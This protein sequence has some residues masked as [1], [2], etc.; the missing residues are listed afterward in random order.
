MRNILR[1][2][3]YRLVRGKSLYIT[4]AVLLGV[5]LLQILSGANMN[6]GVSTGSFVEMDNMENMMEA[7]INLDDLFHS[8]TGAEAPFQAM[9]VTSN[10]LY[11]ML[12]LFVIIGTAD[13]SSGGAKN[14]LSGGVSRAKYYASKLILSCIGCTLLLLVYVLFSTLLATAVNGFG[15]AFDGAFMSDVLKIFLPQLFLC[16]A[17]V[18]VGHFFV[19]LF[20]RSGAFTGVYIA[21]LLLPGIVIMLLTLVSDGFVRLY[22]YELTMNISSLTQISAMSAGEIARTV[23][24]GTGYIIAAAIGGYALF[25]RAEIK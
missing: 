16:L 17:G 14:T 5:V 20:Q 22:D 8:P 23:A 10:I 18:C 19:F 15:G 25:K 6:A 1:A 21:F 7:E 11:F 9:D 4:F 13:F 3:I 12:P 2:D 24:V